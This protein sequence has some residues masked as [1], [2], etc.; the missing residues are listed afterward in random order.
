MRAQKRQRLTLDD[1][2]DPLELGETIEWPVQY[3]VMTANWVPVEMRDKYIAKLKR[4]A[5]DLHELKHGDVNEGRKVLNSYFGVNVGV[6]QGTAL[7]LVFFWSHRQ[8]ASI[9]D[10]QYMTAKLRRSFIKSL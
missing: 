8:A 9:I 2:A 1:S 7:L 5:T 6:K 3:P 10:C 4:L